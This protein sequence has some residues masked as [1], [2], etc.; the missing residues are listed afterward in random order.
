MIEGLPVFGIGA[1][2]V[3]DSHQYP[4]VDSHPTVGSHDAHIFPDSGCPG[5]VNG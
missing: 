4:R 5:V 2:A 3:G 1:E